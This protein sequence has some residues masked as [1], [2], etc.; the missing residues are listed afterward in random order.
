LRYDPRAEAEEPA[1]LY[2]ALLAHAAAAE[3]AGADLVWLS[4]RPFARGARV[5]AAL[6][7]CAAVAA[8]TE[9]L[10]IGVGPLP[11]PLYHPLRLAEDAAALDGLSGGRLEVAVGLGAHHEGYDGFGVSPRER[12]PRF[13]EA[14]ALLR[15]AWR[16]GPIEFDGPFHRVHGIALHPEPLQAG[17]P[18]LWFGADAE[19]AV[20]RAGR[21]ADGLLCPRDPAAPAHFLAAWRE[22]GRSPAGARLA[23]DLAL[24][25][26]PTAATAQA[27]LDA[28]LAR[29]RGYAALDVLLPAAPGAAEADPALTG[30][31]ALRE[32]IKSGPG[33]SDA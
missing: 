1:R 6:P 31:A 33:A 23:L 20:R 16:G 13:E 4:E 7:L 9:R 21:L 10:R 12:V 3:R 8:R 30:L 2:P 25:P 26:H 15:L 19:A 17:G 27:A 11:L 18:P 24:G 22:A 5:P 32:R 29:A 14:V 28:A